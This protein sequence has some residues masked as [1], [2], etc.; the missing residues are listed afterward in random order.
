MLA[1]R[2]YAHTM[3]DTDIERHWGKPFEVLFRELFSALD[4]DYK[5][6]IERYISLRSEFPITAHPGAVEALHTLSATYAVSIVTSASRSVVLEDIH[7]LGFPV[8]QM[9]TIQ[10]AE[11]SA[12]HKPDP[13]VFSPLKDKLAA[14]GIQP[15]EVMYVGDAATDYIAARDAGFTFTGFTPTYSLT[16]PFKP[17]LV[18][19]VSDLRQ[20]TQP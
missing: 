16:N 12:H 7:A 4:G 11:D 20:L 19:I 14:Q 15:H 3:T 9:L 13:Q 18:P 1:Y 5:R 10:C 17:F 6:V 2:F 8:A